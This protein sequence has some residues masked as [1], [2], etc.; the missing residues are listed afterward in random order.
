[1]DPEHKQVES[2]GKLYL[3]Q[4]GDAAMFQMAFD[5]FEALY[6]KA[7]DDDGQIVIYS[8]APY[9]VQFFS[10]AD[11]EAAAR[12]ANE[13]SK[14][15]DIYHVVNLISPANTAAILARKGRG[16]ETE[17]KSV[18]ALVAE[19][20]VASGLHTKTDY[21]TQVAALE[22]LANMPLAPSLVNLSGPQDGGLHAYWLLETPLDVSSPDTRQRVKAISRSWQARLRQGLLPQRV[23]STFDLVRVL[24]IA[25]CVNHK[26]GVPTWPL[27]FD[28]HRRY[29]LE[30]FARHV[31]LAAP[32]AKEPECKPPPGDDARVKRCRSYLRHIPDAVSGKNGH[33]CTFRAACECFRFGLSLSEAKELMS[34]FNDHKTPAGDK[35]SAEELD[36]KLSDAL[37]T[38]SKAG[39]FACRLESPPAQR[40]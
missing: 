31:E 28:G 16:R 33:A 22:A 17:L 23:D 25:G 35:W 36:H 39:Q 27:A 2:A 4:R 10:P 18:V 5:H 29:R 8:K 6:G 11:I 1:M 24:R 38:V 40:S 15:G 20:D 21:P 3:Q 14:L 37:Q 7:R 9:G 26:Y 19:L 30:D 34:W 12:F 13:R 32:E